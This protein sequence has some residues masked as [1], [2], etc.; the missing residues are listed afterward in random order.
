MASRR[1]AQI[2]AAALTQLSFSLA[3][4]FGGLVLWW[5]S[6]GLVRMLGITLAVLGMIEAIYGSWFVAKRK[7]SLSDSGQVWVVVVWMG[8]LLGG[9]ALAGP[10]LAGPL[11]CLV[12]LILRERRGFA[13]SLSIAATV[14]IVLWLGLGKAMGINMFRGLPVAVLWG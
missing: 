13:F 12:W 5:S 1:A 4:A 6:S 10:V 9:M 11:F 14:T 8:P 7:L 2:N 3:V